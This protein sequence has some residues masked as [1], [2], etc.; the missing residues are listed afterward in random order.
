[1]KGDIC[2]CGKTISRKG[3][4]CEACVKRKYRADNPEKA[5]FQLLLSNAR[6]RGIRMLITIEQWMGWTKTEEGRRYMDAKGRGANDL[7]IDRDPVYP[8]EYRI[9]N[10][11]V[12]TLSENAAKG[13]T[14][15]KQFLND[16]LYPDV[17][18]EHYPVSDQSIF[19]ND[20]VP[21]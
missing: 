14:S 16:L 11:K 13:N 7:T 15:D 5:T 20:K 18:I 19:D 21:F 3:T 8:R 10:I 9:D 6:R 4:M 1:M 17:P 12:M 2:S